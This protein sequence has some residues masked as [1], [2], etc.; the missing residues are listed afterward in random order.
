MDCNICTRRYSNIP[1]YMQHLKLYHLQIYNRMECPFCQSAFTW[2]QN[3]LRHIK[4]CG[5]QHT[6]NRSP[7][8]LEHD[9]RI[10][11]NDF[12]TFQTPPV[13]AECVNSDVSPEQPICVSEFTKDFQNNAVEHLLSITSNTDMTM[14]RAMEIIKG[15]KKISNLYSNILQSSLNIQSTIE[16]RELLEVAGNPYRSIDTEKKFLRYLKKEGLYCLPEHYVIQKSIKTVV[17]KGIHKF[18]I[19]KDTATIMPIEFMLKSFLELPGMFQC[20]QNKMTELMSSNDKYEHFV[21]G[22]R[23][24]EIISSDPDKKFLPY[25]IYHDDFDVGNAQGTKRGKQAIGVINL[26]LPLLEDYELSKLKFIFPLAFVKKSFTKSFRKSHCFKKLIDRLECIAK[27]GIEIN[28][29]GKKEIVYPILGLIIGD[30]LAQHE[31]MDLTASFTHTFMCRFCRM[32]KN[33]RQ[34]AV[35]EKPELFRTEDEY[36]DDTNNLSSGVVASSPFNSIPYFHVYRNYSVDIMHDILEGAIKIGLQRSIDDFIESGFFTQFDFERLLDNFDYGEIDSRNRLS[37]SNYKDGKLMLNSKDSLLLIK[38]FTLLVGHKIPSRNSTLQ[39]VIVLEKLVNLCLSNSFDEEKLEVLRKTIEKHNIL[40][41]KF[42]KIVIDKNTKKEKKVYVNLTP[43]LHLLLHYCTVIM[44]SGPVSK[45]WSMRHEGSNRLYKT[46]SNVNACKINLSFSLGKKS[47]MKF[48]YFLFM[49]RQGKDS[50]FKFRN[51]K[52]LNNFDEK[53]YK[54][55]VELPH[56]LFDSDSYE[57]ISLEY[58]GTEYKKGYYVYF[59]DKLHKVIDIVSTNDPEHIYLVLERL[60]IRRSTPNYNCF[61]V[62]DSLE[63]YSV[64]K[65]EICGKPFNIVKIV[66]GTP[67]FKIN[68]NL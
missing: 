52:L 8:R 55:S 23:W 19:K 47:A 21:Q 11:N 44:Y 2:R 36:N 29:E 61:F 46:Y 45:I 60:E 67:V 6:S 30:N 39:Y 1:S 63:Q 4:K 34:K 56:Q 66:D 49:Q 15:F 65:I 59:D 38:Y 25:H 42:Q 68:Q 33:E 26:H 37:S 14:K 54:D 50:I 5:N 51:R 35:R 28:V 17:R 57:Y 32:D 22:K 64:E 58:K 18:Q 13:Q 3:F 16:K 48:A 12:V 53:T 10:L 9:D 7:P 62:G 20:M 40:Y 41:Q 24:R 43:K 27:T 31:L